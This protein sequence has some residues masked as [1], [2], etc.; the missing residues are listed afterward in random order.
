MIQMSWF[1][2]ENVLRKSL[3][4]RIT[5]LKENLTLYLLFEKN[6]LG[7]VTSMKKKLN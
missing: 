3:V 2:E 6:C 4:K 5:F 7:N 1:P